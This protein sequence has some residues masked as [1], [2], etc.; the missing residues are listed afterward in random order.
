LPSRCDVAVIGG[1]FTGLS[2]ACHLAQRGVQVVVLEATTLGAGASGRTGGIV[3]EG[4]AAGE[5]PGVE[6]CLDTLASVVAAHHIACDLRLPGCRELDH[7]PYPGARRAFWRDG[8]TWL[9]IADT[10][11][12]GTIDPGALVA[13]LAA[14]ASAAG[15]RVHEHAAVRALEPGAP[16]RLHTD[17]GMLSADRVIVAL[18]AYTTELL[19]LPVP[20]EAA[21]TLALCTEPLSPKAIEAIGL[22][23]GLPFY[24]LDLPY[25]WGRTTRDGRLVLGAGLVMAGAGPVSE[26]TIDGAASTDALAGLEARLARFHPAL[27]EVAIRERWGGPIAFP[28]R[29][30]PILSPLRDAPQVLVSAGCSGHGIALGV[31]A[32]QLLTDAI[33]DCTPLP[34][35]GVLPATPA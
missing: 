27:A 24:T 23:D 10:V 15:A 33:V 8:E 21:L 2:A 16:T 6:H 28:P 34:A 5:L 14:A 17:A 29:R 7:R 9:R 12:G 22:E 20:L 26:V 11:P 35:W 4:T 1:G 19:R 13:G 25:L 30:A 18:N 32:G 3:L 31:R